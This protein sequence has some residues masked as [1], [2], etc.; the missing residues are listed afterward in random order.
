MNIRTSIKNERTDSVLCRLITEIISPE[1]KT[2]V[3]AEAVAP[4]A[5]GETYQFN[6]NMAVLHPQLWNVG[7]GK[8]YK[9]VSH[10]YVAKEKYNGNVRQPMEWTPLGAGN[11]NIPAH[12]DIPA[13]T[14]DTYETP[15][16]IREIELTPDQGLLVNGKKV[17]VNGVCLHADLGPLGTAS[18]EEGWNQRL[19]ALTEDLGC[20]GILLSYNAYPKYVL[21]WAD[22]HGNLVVD[23]FF[24]KW[25]ESYY[26]KGARFGEMH[27]RDVRIQMERD[28]NH[29]SVFIWSVGNEVYQQIQA[30][31]TRKNGIPNLVNSE[32]FTVIPFGSTK[33]K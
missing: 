5:G 9:A 22:R 32:G 17:Y 18:F 1:G 29:P 6:Q 11:A 2:V 19:K 13:N 33:A 24:D 7:D 14:I 21:D 10:V 8:M 27:L 16:G 20:N 23:E 12:A 25:D 4:F 15:F 31:Q 30:E 26:G 28:R 3:A